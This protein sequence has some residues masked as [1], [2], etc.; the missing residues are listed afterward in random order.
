MKS[1]WYIRIMTGLSWV[2]CSRWSGRLALETASGIEGGFLSATREIGIINVGGKG[3]VYAGNAEYELDKLDCLYIGRGVKRVEFS[4]SASG[5]SGGVVF[6]VRAGACGLSCAVDAGSGGAAGRMS[7]L[8]RLR[9]RGPSINTSMP[10]GSKSCQLV[11]GLTI[12]K[13]RQCLEYDA[14]AYPYPADGSLFLF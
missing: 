10:M 2:G 9:M 1:G 5:A 14:G 3:K 11:M 13:T 12:L 7:D 6:A 4:K 8:R